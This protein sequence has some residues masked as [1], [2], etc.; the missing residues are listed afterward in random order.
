MKVP[1][2][3][4]PSL[5][6]LITLVVGVLVLLPFA[7]LVAARVSSNQFVR[8]T[9]GNL[10]AQ[11]AIYASLFAEAFEAIEPNPEFGALLSLDMRERLAKDFYPTNPV[12]VSSSSSILPPRP[13]VSR[14]TTAIDPIYK[15]ISGA[16][17]RVATTAKKTTLVGVLI[18]DHRGNI[19]AK[20][21]SELGRLA[22]IEEVAAA[23]KGEIV[24]VARWRAEEYRN[25]SVRS[26]SRDTKFR[27]FVTH[28]VVVADRIVGAVY[29]SRTPS[30]LNKYLF[31]Q[32]NTFGWLFAL[33]TSAAI[34]VGFSLWRFLT[35]PLYDLKDQA[36]D[37]ANGTAREKLPNYGVTE[38]A[39]LG[40]SIMDMGASLRKQAA[41]LETYTK[42]ATHE[43]KSPVTSIMGAAELLENPVVDDTRR[44][45]LAATI[46]SDAIRMNKLLLRM[47]EMVRSKAVFAPL[48]VTLSQ[49]ATDASEP[50]L[51]LAISTAGDINSTLP[52]SKDALAICLHH[53]LENAQEHEATEI[54]LTYLAQARVLTMEDNGLGI[55]DAN[56]RQAVEPFFTT[57]RETGGTGLGLAICA[58]VLAAFHG[59]IAIK[60]D[61]TGAIVVI[62]FDQA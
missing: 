35:R 9:E 36:A 60:S 39:S 20:S 16:L 58:E 6:L 47:R 22:H 30:N 45:A 43:L 26:I 21:G 56:A 53:L 33:L 4:R 37:I 2:K 38:I 17:T 19:I 18:T 50:F 40:Q 10:H 51:K 23:L 46:K 48:A 8:E 13:D 34:I 41:G 61:G 25:H 5:G 14:I 1:N 55:L 15:A 3:W 29:L 32:R 57:K 54:T 11:A 12:L 59:S 42:H 27:V 44:L 62:K 28:P 49:A 7:A 24:S 31:Q 52:I